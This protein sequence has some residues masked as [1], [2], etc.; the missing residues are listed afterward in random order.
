MVDLTFL[1]EF[2][3]GNQDRVKRYIS[4]YLEQ[5]P[6]ILSRMS[7]ALEDKDY[8]DMAIHAHSLKPQ[9][10]FMGI[11]I[12]KEKL[13]AIENAVK[14]NKIDGLEELLA[15]VFQIHNQASEILKSHIN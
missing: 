1:Q 8:S 5:A 3:K 10:D 9:T 15:E 11:A 4:M 14:E 6:D 2:S 12:L 13:I 7:S